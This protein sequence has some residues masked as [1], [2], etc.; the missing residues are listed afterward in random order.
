L[1]RKIALGLILVAAAVLA[2]THAGDV[3]TLVTTARAG[4]WQLLLL[5]VVLQVGYYAGYVAT[6]RE[7]FL[8]AGVKR[9]YRELVPVILASVFVNTVTPAGGTAGPVLLVDDASR[10]GYPGSRSAAAVVAGQFADFA[11][12]AVVMLVG[13]I[14][15]LIVG[16][17]RTFEVVA[18][19]LFLGLLTLFALALI[20]AWRRSAVLDRLLGWAESLVARVGRMFGRVFEPGWAARVSSEFSTGVATI[21][22]NPRGLVRSWLAAVAGHTLDLACFVAI[23]FAFGWRGVG[24][25]VAAYA[26]GIVV[27]LVSIIPQGVGLVEGVIALVLVS[28]GTPAA[29][30]AAISLVFRGM[31]FWLPFAI[32]AVSLRYTASFEPKRSAAIKRALV[33]RTSAVIVAAIGI[34]NIVSAVTPGI[35][36]RLKIVETYLPF[37]VQYG[38]LSA[39]LAGLALMVLARGLWNRKRMAWVLT[40]ALLAISVVSHLV[41]GLD[42][43]EAL[44]ALAVAIWLLVERREFYSKSDVPSIWHGLRVLLTALGATVAYGTL[45]FFLLDRHFS[46]NFGFTAA[47]RQTVIMFAQF[48]DPGLQPI[49][50]FG[51]YFAD[52]IYVVGAVSVGYALL[53]I[54]RSVLVRHPASASQH[55]R[56]SEIVRHHGRSS[57][58]AIALLPDKAYWFSPGGSV[59][60]YVGLQGVGLALGDPIGP[61]EDAAAAVDGF[62]AFS[63]SNGWAPVFYQTLDEYLDIYEAAGF[64]A[65][66]IGHEAVVDVTTFSVAGK[67]YRNIRNRVNRIDEDGYTAVM[68]A[69]PISSRLLRELREVSDAWLNRVHGVE[70]R[71]SLGWFDDA[72][73]RECPIMAVHD[74]DGHIVAFANLLSEYERP[75]ATI[76]LMRHADDAPASVMEYLFVKLFFWAAENNYQS[77]NMGLSPLAGIGEQAADPTAEKILRL[78]YEHAN[79]FYSFKGLHAFKEKF[80][81]SWEPRY[82]VFP[83]VGSLPAVFAALTA[84]DSGVTGPVDYVRSLLRRRLS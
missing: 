7:A 51:R 42:F 37:Q 67:S 36:E 26:V 19:L 77:F 40:E 33:V 20:L 39:T 53:M 72:Y 28:F 46:V 75:E 2:F 68:H 14:Y 60:P 58:A 31:T 55:I 70:K 29:S 69:P 25:L 6:Y 71:F 43:E 15:L 81:P 64:S 61:Q 16:R 12:F 38:H 5:A 57:L 65:V 73:L 34:M 76:D 41:K 32:G 82:L 56:A 22:E 13:M 83:D 48:Y 49:T 27:W 79:N 18:A 54:L 44:A 9:G 24:S 80:H 11:G 8:A 50:G 59:V 78:V 52:S 45:G 21:A 47:V 62:R 35:A 63:A 17:L 4:S 30:A 1:Y 10:R 74:S 66:R 84:A 23:G 3:A